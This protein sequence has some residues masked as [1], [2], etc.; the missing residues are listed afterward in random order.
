MEGMTE[1]GQREVC[2]V[3]SVVTSFGESWAGGETWRVPE[4]LDG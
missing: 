1:S 3:V 2:V 4:V